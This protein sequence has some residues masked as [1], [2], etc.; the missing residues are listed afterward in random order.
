MK[1]SCTEDGSL[2]ETDGEFCFSYCKYD[3]SNR[4]KGYI[5]REL[6][7]MVLI[8]VPEVVVVN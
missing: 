1:I 2:D 3:G 8:L 5:R 4:E 7:F 6:C